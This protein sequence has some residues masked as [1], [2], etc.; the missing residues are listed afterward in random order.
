MSDP[1][2]GSQHTQTPPPPPCPSSPNREQLHNAA[3]YVTAL[4]YHHRAQLSASSLPLVHP[5]L[6]WLLLAHITPALELADVRIGPEAEFA[7]LRLVFAALRRAAAVRTAELAGYLESI[8]IGQQQDLLAFAH[9]HLSDH[10][11]Q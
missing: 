3:A 4:A 5:D 7:V 2:I 1:G 6:H 8:T 9:R 11:T 10:V